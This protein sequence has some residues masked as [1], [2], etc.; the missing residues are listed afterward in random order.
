MA[1]ATVPLTALSE[2]QRAQALERLEIIRPAVEKKV[3]QA[4]VARTHE[5]PA[6][7][8]QLWVKQYRE[9]GLAGLAPSPRSD[10]GKSRNLPDQAVT[11]V[12]GLA[13]QTPPRSAAAIHRQ[14][15]E[16]AKDQ[17]W[18]PP[19]YE[20]VRQI[21]KNLDPALTT[22]AHQGTAA[23][24][25][26]FDLLYRREST[27][28]NAMWQ[29]DHTPLDVMLLDEEG[30][31]A[32]PY[33]TAI[34]DDYSR[35]I[36]GY[37]LSFQV[38]TALTTALTLRQAIWRKDDPR[39]SACGIPT[40]FYTDHGSDFTS[41]HLEQVSG[42]IG[43][44]LVFSKIGVPRGR[45][46]VERFF[47][48]VDQL[49]LQDVPGYSPKGY[50]EAK[51]V[52]TLPAFEQL[53]RK[54]LLEDFHH[55]VHS[56]TG[57]IPK[58]RWEAGGYVPRMPASIDQL[59]LLLLTVAKTRKVQQD[60]I[61]FQNHRYMDITLAAFVK[62]EV[63]IRY[64]PADMGEIHVFYQDRFL[65]R[66]ICAELSDRKVTLK[67]IEQARTARR[68][69]VR[70]ELNTREAIVNRYVELH[71]TPPPTPKT[72]VAESAPVEART[73]LKRYIND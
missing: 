59:D 37:R 71:H 56:E 14:V 7:T 47:R 13:L 26:E 30:K 42:D 50:P 72:V 65:C 10:K 54:W 60:G 63:L 33:L 64:D 34:E 67:E 12:E 23:Y 5:L 52:L 55:R 16:I 31:P 57:F 28:A 20:R 21:I 58:D 35:L 36:V 39:W 66:A 18:K 32:K 43:M 2:K 1:Q 49:F 24:R 3:S 19:S 44:E 73:T 46:K 40:V 4:Q 38:A 53:F 45:G 25:E 61:H 69:Q 27:H 8:V 17:R 29:A 68:K 62:E 6:S 51:A 15:V 70:G 11:L 41:K 48:S 9:K 22:L